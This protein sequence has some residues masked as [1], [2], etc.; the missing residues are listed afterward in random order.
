MRPGERARLAGELLSGKRSAADLPEPDQHALLDELIR[1]KCLLFTADPEHPGGP[2]RLCL[3]GLAS[4][5]LAERL[6]AERRRCDSQRAAL[7][8]AQACLEQVGIPL[9]LFKTT[10]AYPYTSSN[11]DALVPEGTLRRAVQA[12][13]IEGFREMTHYWEPNKRLLRRFHGRTCELELHLHEQVSWMVLTFLEPATLWSGARA[14]ADPSVRHPAPEHVVA[15]LLAH[16]VYESNRVSLGDAAKI[17]CAVEQPDFDWTEVVRCAERRSWL[18]GLALARYWYAAAERA[19]FGDARLDEPRCV[20]GL[21][22]PPARA[23]GA[24]GAAVKLGAWPLELSK[25]RTK[26][27]FFRKLLRDNPRSAR[28]KL[29][30]LVG[31]F[32]QIV[33][34][35]LG[36][37]PRPASLLCVCGIDGSGKSS[38][39]EAL[40][41]ALECC[42][43]PVRV[44]WM[45][46]GYSAL[47]EGVK[48]LARRSS[49]R[50]P[51]SGDA[52][53]KTRV[54]RGGALRWVWAWWVALEQVSLAV[55]RV[56]L[57]RGL[58]RTVVTQRYVPDTLVD[59]AQRFGVRFAER[60]PGRFL[61]R[62]TPEPDLI[63]LLDLDGATA[64]ARKPDD[65]SSEILEVRRALYRGVLEGRPRVVSLDARRPR[66]Q[67]EHEVVDRGLQ[68]TFRRIEHD[69]RLARQRRDSWE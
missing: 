23:R 51:R 4:E 39:A 24:V 22:E 20:E 44:V 65:W 55:L 17:R 9:L 54:Y 26:P 14:S 34:G 6:E 33:P 67:L 27:Y 29:W 46:G 37:R 16:S 45:R 25:W 15:A 43:V 60:A 57:A 3:P 53:A 1:G 69:S 21:P 19:A 66:Q 11:V 35:R 28:Q 36:L 68:F 7:L 10:G 2:S 63:L 61:R 32:L 31:L 64:F 5:P 18:P 40:R 13:E 8:Q 58:G 62:F 50:V 42:E 48:R 49:S 56:R 41:T 38:H 30:D 12:L 59:L 52:S 47:S